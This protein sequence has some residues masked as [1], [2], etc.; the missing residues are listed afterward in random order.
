MSGFIREF[1]VNSI[2][3]STVLER[4]EKLGRK[5][6]KLGIN[7]PRILSTNEWIRE[8]PQGQGKKPILHPMTG[9]TVEADEIKL[10]GY[11]F[12]ASLD[13]S[14]TEKP[15]IKTIPGKDIPEVYREAECKCDH[16]GVNRY[17][18]NTYIFKNNNN[19][20]LQVGRNCLAVYFGIDP[21]LY[22]DWFSSFYELSNSDN[23]GNGGEYYYSVLDSIAI[24]LAV[25]D[26]H[27]YVS[28]KTANE[29]RINTDK[30]IWTSSDRVLKA[31]Y[32]SKYM[33]D[34]E[35]EEHRSLMEKADTMKEKA[36]EL[37]S[38]GIDY[39][40][41]QNSEYAHNMSQF[42]SLR[43]IPAKYMGYIVS[44]IP[45]YNKAMDLIEPKQNKRFDNQYIGNIGDKVT[46]NVTINKVIPTE[47]AYGITYIHLMVQKD[48]GNNLVWFCSSKPLEE[49][50]ELTIKGSIKA[51]NNRD[52][53]NQTVLTRCKVV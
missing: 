34:F 47:G 16:C 13:H 21:T 51:L 45:S 46:V 5:A 31:Y 40:K 27:G 39:F 42:L 4:L 9:F 7:P 1:S 48:T 43:E 36:Q 28:K 41:T 19:Q 3:A 53:K 32:P 37:I 23:Y 50:A 8:E 17:R 33:D 2:H 12:I 14:L 38:W 29:I 18:K 6:E 52:G 20:F 25:V 35:R 22:L 49:K 15:I 24:G 11:T 30:N 10:P 26:T 44:V